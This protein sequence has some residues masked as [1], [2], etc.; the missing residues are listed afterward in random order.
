MTI[1]CV[2][3]I[4]GLATAAPAAGAELDWGALLGSF[5]GFATATIV[6]HLAGDTSRLAGAITLGRMISWGVGGMAVGAL[7]GSMIP[8]WERVPL[9]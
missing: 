7:A 4:A 1:R 3:L 8:E 6:G 5:A 9:E 2:L